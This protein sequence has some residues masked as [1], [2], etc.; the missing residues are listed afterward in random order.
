MKKTI[1][2]LFVLLLSVFIVSCE[3]TESADSIGTLSFKVDFSD[4]SLTRSG[5]AEGFPDPATT[6]NC[7]A[8]DDLETKSSEM[9]AIFSLTNQKEETIEYTKKIRVEDDAFLT[10]PLE[11]KA[12]TYSLTSFQIRIDA[13]IVYQAIEADHELEGVITPLPI[14]VKI[15]E[16]SNYGKTITPISV[17]CSRT[18]E[19]NPFGYALFNMDFYNY[20]TVNF[21]VFNGTNRVAGILTINRSLGEDDEESEEPS[22]DWDVFKLIKSLSFS[23]TGIQNLIFIDDLQKA[24]THEKYQFNFSVPNTED[25]ILSKSFELD[26]TDLLA[27]ITSLR[28]EETMYKYL[29]ID[30]AEEE[31]HFEV[32]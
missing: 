19:T 21:I 2:G 9:Q 12:G 16:T 1:S 18:I 23:E 31:L 24:D 29:Y 6:A 25:P 3:K 5:D 7:L 30:L 11:L 13:D 14:E 4:V 27:L 28:S 32:R 15:E 8:S 10:L 20:Y 17:V 22:I 26:V